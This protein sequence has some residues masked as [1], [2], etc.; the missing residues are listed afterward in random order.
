[1]T[2]IRARLRAGIAA[3]T[4]AAFLIAAL[5]TGQTV[6][7]ILIADLDRSLNERAHWLMS[8]VELTADSL[9]MGFHEFELGEFEAERGASLLEVWNAEGVVLYRSPSLAAASLSRP[10]L[11]PGTDRASFERLADGRRSRTYSA[12]FPSR[13]DPELENPPPAPLVTLSFG[14][15][16]AGIDALMRQLIAA[17]AMISLLAALATLLVLRGVVHRSLAPLARIAARIA[18]LDTRDLGARVEPAGMPSEIAPV[19]ARLNE[20]LAR[21]A[22]SFERERALTADIA[23][24]LRTPLAGLRTGIE[25]ELSRPREAFRYREALGE[26]LAITLRLQGMSSALLQLA[27]LER[28]LESPEREPTSLDAL[29]RE[30]LDALAERSHERR[31]S[32]L[33]TSESDLVIHTDRA[34]VG[35]ALRNVLGNAVEHAD[36][37]GRVSIDIRRTSTGASV[38]VANTGARVG[39]DAVAGL[40]DRFVRGDMARQAAGGHHGLGLA[41]VRRIAEVLG[42]SVEASSEIGG[43]FALT[44]EL[45]DTPAPTGEHT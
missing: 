26:A 16:L 39:Q 24:E 31:L 4:L 22:E 11:A 15:D 45:P 3:C 25:V 12:C 1:M 37:G 8:T 21:V 34:L 13:I 44:I 9:E 7:H 18:A 17:L 14:R 20:L 28:G 33:V 30:H 2:S 41:L 19:V 29:V 10:A 38:R 6:R 5:V 32:V 40:F 42:A 23:H 27:R 35:T 43:E 36:E